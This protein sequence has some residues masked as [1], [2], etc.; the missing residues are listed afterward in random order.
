VRDPSADQTY[1]DVMTMKKSY[2]DDTPKEIATKIS[3]FEPSLWH[4]IG[5]FHVRYGLISVVDQYFNDQSRG[6]NPSYP[7]ILLVGDYGYGRRTLARAIHNAFGNLE[8]IEP[9]HTLGVS[10]DPADFFQKTTP[11]TTIY[12]PNVAQICPSVV[13]QIIYVL[14]DGVCLSSP[15]SPVTEDVHIGSRLMIFSA[16][17]HEKTDPDLLRHITHRFELCG[18]NDQQILKILH[19]RVNGLSWQATNAAL[20]L[21]TRS[22]QNNPYNA[23]KILQM[24]R[25]VARAEDQDTIDINH[26]KRAMA[27]GI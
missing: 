9:A 17:K 7:S 3:E 2:M 21:I 15:F 4:L 16:G 20:E 19:Q 14:R 13:G 8:F 1:H 27:V 12:L 22:A 6:R 11:S 18:Y 10:E 25:T 24:S 26:V 23:M 5:L